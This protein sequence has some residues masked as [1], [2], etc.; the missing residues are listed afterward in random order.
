[1]KKSIIILIFSVFAFNSCR[2]VIGL[3]SNIDKELLKKKLSSSDSLNFL[4]IHDL[5]FGSLKIGTA[6]H[7]FVTIVNNSV[8]DTITIYKLEPVDM[9]GLFSYNFPQGFPFRIYPGEDI[10][11]TEKI[12]V[13]FIA[14]DYK[15]NYHYDSLM[16]NNNKNFIIKVKA[17]VRY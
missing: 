14:D 1:M 16:I 13:Q 8:K 4:T 15:F 12:R 10:N 7:D 17:K 6:N 3:D 2:D 9:S 11:L 5:D